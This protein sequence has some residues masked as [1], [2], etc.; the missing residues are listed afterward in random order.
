[1]SK[2][3][4]CIFVGIVYQLGLLVCFLFILAHEGEA[5]PEIKIE[6]QP[7]LS[8]LFWKNNVRILQQ[9]VWETQNGIKI[10][11]GLVVLE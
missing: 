1:M 5:A 7:K 6:G 4:Q 2:V 3:K 10:S 8:T 11:V 9:I